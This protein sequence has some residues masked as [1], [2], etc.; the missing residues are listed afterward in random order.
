MMSGRVL[1]VMLDGVGVG[2]SDPALNPFFQANLPV[3]QGALG[4]IPSLDASHEF[5]PRDS[6]PGDSRSRSAQTFSGR[7]MT[8]VLLDACL[9]T[10]GRPQS[11][12]GQTALLTGVNAAKE[13]GRHFGPWTPTKIRPLLKEKNI[14]SLAVE[15]GRDVAFAN[16]YPEDFFERTHG[17]RLAAPPLAAKAAGVFTRHAEALGRGDGVASEILNTGWRNRLGHTELPI[18][19]AFE[20]GEALARITSKH[21][22]TF[23]AHYRTD[24]AGHEEEMDPAVEALERVDEFLGG[25]IATMPED[26]TLIVA[27]D[28]GN[29]EDISGGHTRNP[30][31]GLVFGADAEILVKPLASITDVAPAILKKLG[32]PI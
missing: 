29:I 11:G 22:L 14:L 28:H 25:V 21:H 20:A 1:L 31:L 12:T 24:T 26:G 15:A 4:K 6:K 30:V 23:Y 27:S 9:D 19:T 13:M 18:V 17:K 3:L 8:A 16:A 2:P 5:Q 7:S 10:D 32:I